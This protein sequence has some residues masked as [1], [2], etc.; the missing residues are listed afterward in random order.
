MPCLQIDIAVAQAHRLGDA[1]PASGE[2]PEQRLVGR[3]AQTAGTELTRG[4]QQLGDFLLGIDVR[5]WRSPMRPKIGIVGDLGA[6]LELL[7]PAQ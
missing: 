4:G 5:R 6:R 1:K 2:Q 7:Q 3:A